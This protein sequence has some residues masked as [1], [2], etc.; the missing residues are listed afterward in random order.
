MLKETTRR[1]VWLKESGRHGG[2][3]GKR[4]GE[5][6]AG[7]DYAVPCEAILL[8]IWSKAKASLQIVY[9]CTMRR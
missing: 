7:P 1:P 9:Y 6:V 5:R 2:E 8:K 4:L 3:N